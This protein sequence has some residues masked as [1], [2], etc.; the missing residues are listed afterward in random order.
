MN[1]LTDRHTHR[2]WKATTWPDPLGS[3][4]KTAINHKL[5]YIIHS[6]DT[7]AD[8]SGKAGP[9][10]GFFW[11]KG[12]VFFFFLFMILWQ[13]LRGVQHFITFWTR[14]EWKVT[15]VS[16]SLTEYVKFLLS[17]LNLSN[18]NFFGKWKKVIL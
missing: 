1:R 2:N 15:K 6:L 9:L 13:R 7:F 8:F 14:Q 12:K 11:Q 5:S 10:Y 3:S 16:L 4:N 17:L 18:F